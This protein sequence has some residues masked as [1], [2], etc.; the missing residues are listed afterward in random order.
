ME[1]IL[2]IFLGI[3]LSSGGIILPGL[4][5]MT[6]VKISL[7]DGR[8]RAVIFS[9]GATTVVLIQCYIAVTFAKFIDRNP[10]IK[11]LLQEIGL[12]VFLVLTIYF[13]F[14]AKTP[15]LKVDN[16]E[17]V[18]KL[19]S[20][21]G[22]FFLGVLLSALNFFPIP[23]YVFVSITLYTYGY[24]YFTPLYIFLFVASAVIG[25]FSTFYL[26]IAFFKKIGTNAAFLMR[27]INYIIGSITG[28]I[29]LITF[30]RI[31]RGA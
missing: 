16:E 6:A 1:I 19:R 28:L 5:N 18:V 3:T 22:E 30:I 15:R 21:T 12:G 4:L 24:F 26:Y 17:E 9:L 10:E 20:K 27:N 7:R 29:A 8:Q 11:D 14:L 2:P 13:I 31:M 25:T 23:Y